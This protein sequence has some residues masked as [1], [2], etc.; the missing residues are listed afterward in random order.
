MPKR[1]AD[2]A[3][4]E[5]PDWN[6]YTVPQLKDALGLRG[7]TRVG[8]KAE[9]IAR[10]ESHEA[11]LA[12]QAALLPGSE[13]AEGSAT[14]GPKSKKSKIRGPEPVLEGP[15]ASEVITN[16]WANSET[17]ER[18]LREFVPAPDDKFKDKVKR[19][20]KE[21]MFMLDREMTNDSA[22]HREEIFTIAGSTGNIYT[23]TIGRSPRCD[24]MDAVSCIFR[25]T[26]TY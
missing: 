5:S 2:N 13:G 23:C 25:F 18:R 16:Q 22:G 14:R 15:L 10:L 3:S 8:R 11:T 12:A 6:S 21:R 1:S 7:L 20:N 17:G 9:L 19:I 4:L 26:A 24:C